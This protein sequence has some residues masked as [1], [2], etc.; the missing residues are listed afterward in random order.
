[1]EKRFFHHGRAI[2]S[3]SQ[4]WDEAFT[5]FY[6]RILATDPRSISNQ[7]EQQVWNPCRIIPNLILPHRHLLQN[8]LI[9]ACG[10]ASVSRLF[11]FACAALSFSLEFIFSN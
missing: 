4:Y 5:S 10:S 2:Q 9:K 11:S 3:N 1:M 8:A 7:G 6:A